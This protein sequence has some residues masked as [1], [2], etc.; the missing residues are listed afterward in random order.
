MLD[1]G[2]SSGR[3][4]RVLHAAFPEIEW[5]A[6]DPIEASIQWATAHLPGVRFA[7]SP[8][9]PPLAYPDEFFD[10]VFAISIWSHFSARAALQWLQEMRRV[11]RPSG[12]LVL[13][14]HGLESIAYYARRNLRP[15]PG[16]LEGNQDVFVFERR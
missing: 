4:V 8:T 15:A 13:T 5:H 7:V 16:L 3:A 2:C 14:T 11:I 12:H 6:C 1:F 9:K 10:R